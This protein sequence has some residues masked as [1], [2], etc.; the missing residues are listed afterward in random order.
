[1]P[2]PD[3]ERIVNSL[4]LYP[5][6]EPALNRLKGELYKELNNV[7]VLGVARSW[8]IDKFR[9]LCGGHYVDLL[10]LYRPL[11]GVEPSAQSA[12]MR[13]FVEDVIRRP[14]VEYNS[15]WLKQAFP[16][17]TPAAETSAPAANT[18]VPVAE[19]EPAARAEESTPNPASPVESEQTPPTEPSRVESAP[20]PPKSQAQEPSPEGSK[21]E[22]PKG[23]ASARKLH[24]VEQDVYNAMKDNP[25]RRGERNYATTLWKTKGFK[26]NGV[27]KK[28]VQNYVSKHRKDLEVEA[29]NARKTDE[30]LPKKLLAEND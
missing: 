26:K 27:A 15:D 4:E 22:R 6:I 21:E 24:G 7:F 3:A 11:S 2:P 13:E 14:N 30:L 20:L 5:E 25:P 10:T 23:A 28:T 18:E 1:M 9:I 12:M 8:P 16:T 29:D 17:T 19:P